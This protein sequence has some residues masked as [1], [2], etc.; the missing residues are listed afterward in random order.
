MSNLEYLITAFPEYTKNPLETIQPYIRPPWWEPRRSI[1][2]DPTKEVTKQHHDTSADY[3]NKPNVL[4]IYTDGS[5]IDGEIGAAAYSSTLTKSEH[6][7]LG[8]DTSFNVYA[9]ELTAVDLAIGIVKNSNPIYTECIMDADSQATIKA[10]IKPKRQSGQEIIQGILYRIESL[11]LQRPSLNITIKWIPGHM[12][13]AGNELVDQEAKKAAKGKGCI[14]KAIP[15]QTIKILMQPN[16][17][18]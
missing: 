18:P 15:L 9:A 7:Y 3:H 13:I 16:H 10:I 14:R 5:G 2:I 17:Q 8:K 1:R 6:Q 11:L 12:D 4:C